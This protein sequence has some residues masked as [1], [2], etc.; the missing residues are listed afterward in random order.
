MPTTLTS[1]PV[2]RVRA[3][4]PLLR[5]LPVILLALAFLVAFLVTMRNEPRAPQRGG[6]AAEQVTGTRG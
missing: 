5:G 3:R 6:E 4:H 2:F 1:H